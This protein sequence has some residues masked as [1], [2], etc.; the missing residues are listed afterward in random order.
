MRVRMKTLYAS[1]ERAVSP[2]QI[3]DF[4]P[5][6]AKALID[7]GYAVPADA[8]PSEGAV[9]ATR[10]ARAPKAPKQDPEGPK[11]PTDPPAGPADGK[12][13]DDLN[14]GPDED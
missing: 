12:G 13:A 3:A 8:D 5:A 14:G 6:E 2:D 1:P 10:R 9:P 11:A 4:P 7:G